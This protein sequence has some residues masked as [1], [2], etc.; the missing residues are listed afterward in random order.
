M[1]EEKRQN[2]TLSDIEM[3]KISD[4]D[5]FIENEK[6]KDE[7][8]KLYEVREQKKTFKIT[9]IFCIILNLTLLL[10]GLSGSW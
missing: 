2:P 4:L 6:R 9:L 8:D 5:S 3:Y 7:L 1:I 10:V